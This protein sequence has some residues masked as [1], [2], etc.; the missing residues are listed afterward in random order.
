ML[1]VWPDSVMGR[2]SG[3]RGDKALVR[4]S[5]Q[6][7]PSDRDTLEVSIDAMKENA[8]MTYIETERTA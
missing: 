6:K 5:M 7:F 1:A 8:W 3:R 2:A 4:P